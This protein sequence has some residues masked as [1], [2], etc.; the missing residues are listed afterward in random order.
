MYTAVLGVQIPCYNGIARDTTNEERAKAIYY[1]IQTMLEI[2]T[3][4]SNE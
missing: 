4:C 1:L 2:K 3:I